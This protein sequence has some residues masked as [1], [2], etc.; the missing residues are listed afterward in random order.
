MC[1]HL[2]N[3]SAKYCFC[4]CLCRSCHHYCR[5]CFRCRFR[6]R[7]QCCRHPAAV[8]LANCDR[9]FVAHGSGP[10]SAISRARLWRQSPL[11]H[12][13][14]SPVRHRSTLLWPLRHGHPT[15]SHCN[16]GAAT[17]VAP[18]SASAAAAK[19]SRMP[20]PLAAVLH[21]SFGR[22]TLAVGTLL[23]IAWGK[24]LISS[25]NE[26][27]LRGCSQTSWKPKIKE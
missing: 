9:D 14:A 24:I 18:P 8:A 13:A 2:S 11:W 3:F 27:L 10:W 15:L 12:P 4:C 7:A 26:T 16:K 25:Q 23:D 20:R 19:R 22:R 6:V 17:S 21:A 1:Q 5:C